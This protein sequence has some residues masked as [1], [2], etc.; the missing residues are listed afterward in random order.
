MPRSE[1][2][3]E[4]ERLH[5]AHTG[6]VAEAKLDR[7]SACSP[8]TSRGLARVGS[9]INLGQVQGGVHFHLPPTALPEPVPASPA[10][11]Y[12]PRLPAVWN[13][14]YRRNPDF[15]GREQLLVTLPSSSPAAALPQAPIVVHGG[16]GVGKTTLA[17]EYAYQQRARFDTAWWVRAEEPTTLVGDY[18]DLA[19]ALGLA[20]AR[21]ADQQLAVLAVRRWLEGNVRWLLVLDNAE[22]PEAPTGLRPPLARTRVLCG[23]HLCAHLLRKSSTDA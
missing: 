13:V 7:L 12:G 23:Q 22:D 18:G 8:A 19:A 6:L 14:P 2:A 9:I 20:E 21:Q 5:A 11:A 1:L 4:D 3:A 15:S 17:A 16:G 10:A